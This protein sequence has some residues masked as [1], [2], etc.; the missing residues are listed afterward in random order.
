MKDIDKEPSQTTGLVMSKERDFG[1]RLVRVAEGLS[2]SA[3]YLLAIANNASSLETPPDMVRGQFKK[4]ILPHLCS[5][6]DLLG[7]SIIDNSVERV[8]SSIEDVSTPHMVISVEDEAK[9]FKRKSLTTAIIDV[10]TSAE[11]PLSPS[12]IKLALETAGV[13]TTLGSISVSLSTH[14][15]L[16]STQQQCD[17]GRKRLYSIRQ[18]AEIT[19]APRNI[20]A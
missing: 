17:D 1:N 6:L 5:A 12:D 9:V 8:S 4:G 14:R 3:S 20:E 13:E 15:N 16:F 2:K 11:K 10:L 19:R 7:Y 18:G